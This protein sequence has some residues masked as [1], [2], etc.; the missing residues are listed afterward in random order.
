MTRRKVLLTLIAATAG[1]LLTGLVAFVWNGMAPRE[2]VSDAAAGR[3][4]PSFALPGLE[5]GG[6]GLTSDDFGG[7]VTV[8]NLFASWCVPC[9]AEHPFITGLSREPGVTVVGIAWMDD[10]AATAAWLAEHGNPYVRIGMDR[11]GRLKQALQIEGVPTTFIIDADG[12][13]RFQRDGPLV[14]ENAVA[15]FRSA[16]DAVRR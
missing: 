16:L 13:I 3:P 4:L 2:P 5:D 1:I 9:L 8:I 15:D 14:A 11:T 12:R 10:P 7:G 6:R